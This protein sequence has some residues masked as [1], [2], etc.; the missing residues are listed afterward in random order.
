MPYTSATAVEID[1]KLREDFRRR[2]K[3]YGV[4]A[5]TT[6]PLLAVLFRTFAQQLEVLYSDTGRIRLALLDELIAGLGLQKRMARPAQTVIRF[7]DTSRTRLIEGGTALT[8]ESTTGAKLTFLT[9]APVTV[10]S[11]RI[12]FAATYE[13]GA[14]RLLG[15]VEMD[16]RFQNARPSLEAVKTNLGPNPALFLAIEPPP[17]GHL[18][19]HGFYFDFSP[20]ALDI[21]KALARETWCLA[22]ESGTFSGGGIL[23]PRVGNAGL[24]QLE[25]LMQKAR[26]NSDPIN[27]DVAPLPPGFYTGKAYVL[28]AFPP[29]KKLLCRQPR[30]LEPALT[31]LFGREA[32]NLFTT[33]RIWIKVTFPRGLPS[34]QTGIGNV[35]LHAITA[36]N[37]EC[38]N[39]TIYFEKHGT[40]I[41]ISKE[42]GT[43]WHLVAPLSVISESDTPYLLETEPSADP[44]VGRY[45]IRNGRIELMPATFPGGKRHAYANVRVWISAGA[46]GNQVGPGKVAAIQLKDYA[47]GLRVSNPTAAAGGTNTEEFADART[48]FTTA[49]LSRDRVVTR[50]DLFAIASSFDRRVLD[51]TIRSAVERVEGA[52]RRVEKVTVYLNKDDFN[53][54]DLEAR[55]LLEDLRGVLAKR[56]LH[57]IELSLQVEW[58][59]A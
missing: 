16:E 21:Q 6:D 45:A 15:G 1:R 10:S 17:E 37:V 44:H 4:N 46:G 24:G 20:D 57:D 48:R 27:D 26:E 11:A 59:A 43:D 35:A 25:W 29:G 23:R 52:L 19:G 56:F 40:A 49:L 30:A 32:P 9:D 18:G 14:L 34:L 51:T 3:E 58:E 42:G 39:Q 13:E 41:P 54:P 36:S 33:E 5:E 7:F 8:G 47:G 2:L 38:L 28:P 55:Y 31:R 22:G 53:D 50:G 12:C